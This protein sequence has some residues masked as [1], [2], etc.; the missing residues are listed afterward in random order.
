MM[1]KSSE[2]LAVQNT[3]NDVLQTKVYPAFLLIKNRYR[4]ASQLGYFEDEYSKF[5]LKNK[6]KLMPIINRGTWARVFAY[7][8]VIDRFLRAL[9][10]DEEK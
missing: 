6:R 10:E 9:P 4:Y 8:S 7:R 2:D 1:K 5:F 3:A